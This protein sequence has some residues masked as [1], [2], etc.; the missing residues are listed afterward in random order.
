[1][2][3]RWAGAV[4]QFQKYPPQ[5]PITADCRSCHPTDPLAASQGRLDLCCRGRGAAGGKL[6]LSCF[7]SRLIRKRHGRSGKR[8]AFA[9][10]GRM[11]PLPRN[12]I[13]AI[14]DA[15][16]LTAAP[17]AGTERLLRPCRR[18][19]AVAD[20]V[21]LMSMPQIAVGR[22]AALGSKMGTRPPESTG[23]I[24]PVADRFSRASVLGS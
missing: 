19:E 17:A 22:H 15:G 7:R 8:A 16:R 9:P 2:G 3:N 18:G 14:S 6:G 20:S 1:M 5:P 24:G 12:P 13:D 4:P 23:V 11:P 10:T 21:R